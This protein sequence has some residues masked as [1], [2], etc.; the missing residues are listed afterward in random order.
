[1]RLGLTV[2]PLRENGF[3][4]TAR[5]ENRLDI[6]VQPAPLGEPSTE[7]G[8]RW[9][10][11][12]GWQPDRE[13]KL[14]MARVDEW[15]GL[16]FVDAFAV[17]RGMINEAMAESRGVPAVVDCFSHRGRTILN[18]FRD[19]FG[20]DTSPPSEYGESYFAWR[21]RSPFTSGLS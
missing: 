1:M 6:R 10:V 15:L 5:Y 13:P 4:L 11:L 2:V 18:P 9:N 12:G 8:L 21:M 19:A 14:H 16:S 17:V 3:I 20:N 7:T